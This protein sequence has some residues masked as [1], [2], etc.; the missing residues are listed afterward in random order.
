MIQKAL[1]EFKI[2]FDNKIKA[3][4]KID[5]DPF[6]ANAYFAEID[7]NICVVEVEF[8]GDQSIDI[9]IDKFEEEYLDIVSLL[10]M[11]NCL[12]T[13]FKRNVKD[14]NSFHEKY[15]RKKFLNPRRSYEHHKK[16]MTYFPPR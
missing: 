10:T 8:L 3:P 11:M 1:E 15:Y 5:D 6:H 9:M 12:W 2:L 7:T 4:I 14:E 13:Y 16:N